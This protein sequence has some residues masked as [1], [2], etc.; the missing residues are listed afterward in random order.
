[1][2]RLRIREHRCSTGHLCIS[3]AKMRFVPPPELGAFVIRFHLLALILFT[4]APVAA[5]TS[6]PPGAVGAIEGVVTTQNGTIRLGGAQL[7]FRN[8]ANQEIATLLS[9]GDGH[10]RV[11]ALLDGKYI[12]SASLEG[13]VTGK[14]TAVVA[15]GRTA[16]V[17]IDLP[18]NTVKE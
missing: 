15:S 17:A 11:T 4:A 6:T 3:Q 2:S 13:F 16:D 7:V 18:I 14:A 8:A 9:E 10:F 12:I 5:Q 1:A